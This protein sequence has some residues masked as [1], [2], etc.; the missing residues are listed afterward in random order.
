MQF[1]KQS[2][3]S[4]KHSGVYILSQNIL[5]ALKGNKHMVKF[6]I[7]ALNLHVVRNGIS[8]NLTILFP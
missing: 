5:S 7:I 8:W 3:N 1:Q 4:Q 2:W 6:F